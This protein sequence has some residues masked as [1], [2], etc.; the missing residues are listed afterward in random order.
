MALLSKFSTLFLY[1]VLVL[2]YVLAKPRQWRRLI[3]SMTTLTVI[4]A[5]IIGIGYWP[6]TKRVLSGELPV[7]RHAYLAGLDLVRQHSSGGHPSYLLGQN[8]DA[9]WWYYF[10]VVFAVKTPT[11][12]LV[13]TLILAP[14]GVRQ[15]LT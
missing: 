13:L 4:S 6:E 14:L 8:S 12:L 3:V 1:P 5:I 7:S 10:P 9:G 2:L 11:V 15:A